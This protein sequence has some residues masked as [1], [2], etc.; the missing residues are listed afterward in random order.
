ML[1]ENF[2]NEWIVKSFAKRLTVKKQDL[3]LTDTSENE[4]SMNDVKDDNF[5]KQ[6]LTSFEIP[7]KKMKIKKSL[8]CGI[9]AIWLKS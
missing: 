9:L 1:F 8:Q 4:T 6:I 2:R 7:N 3:S 5:K